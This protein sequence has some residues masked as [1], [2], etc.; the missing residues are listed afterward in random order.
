MTPTAQAREC[1]R[2]CTQPRR[3]TRTPAPARP[4]TPQSPMLTSS[5]RCR[6]N[7]RGSLADVRQIPLPP[8]RPSA[9]APARYC[10]TRSW[11]LSLDLL[12]RPREGGGKEGKAKR[13]EQKRKEGRKKAK[14]KKR[15][16]SFS[17]GHNTVLVLRMT[18]RK[19][20][21]IKQQPSM[22]P[23]PG[24]P[25]LLLSLYPFPVSHPEQEHCKTVLNLF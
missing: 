12:G 25:W 19:W 17:L 1:C 11:W 9:S 5:C 22:L 6:A 24:S 18:H 14:W 7:R 2:Q 23:G 16:S 20:K 10:L 13:E 21:E 4:H 15:R 3:R 8:V